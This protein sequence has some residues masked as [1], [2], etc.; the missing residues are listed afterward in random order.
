M[1]LA[2][3]SDLHIGYDKFAE[4]AIKQAKEA[5][6]LASTMADAILLP[7]DIFDKRYPR[8]EVMAQAINLFRDM[9]KRS[10]SAK[11]V[12]FEG[13]GKAYTGIPVV[14]ISGTHERTVEGKDNPLNLL[15]LAGFLVDTSEATTIIEKDDER[16]A[17]FG[18]GG[19][20]DERVRERLKELDPKPLP[21]AFNIFMFHQSI[22]ELLPFGNNIMRYDDLPKG[23]DLY[24]CGH[25]HNKVESVVHGKKF[26]ISGSTVL[27]QL[28]DGEQERKGFILFDTATYSYEF[29]YIN[30]REFIS[31]KVHFEEAEPKDVADG[32]ES[33]IESVLAKSSGRPIIRLNL[34]GTI[35][36]G[37][38]SLDM[39][40]RAIADRYA[41]RAILS[42]DASGLV[43]PELES[44]I[45]GIRDN[46]IGDVPIKE[47][48][49]G[50]FA[51]KLNELEFDES[52]DAS[53]LFEILSSPENKDKVVKEAGEF[54]DKG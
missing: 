38:T 12:S 44:S 47:L 23:F 50:L 31:K 45:A 37:F 10:W 41:G 42:I 3:V 49:M 28:K 40:I 1:K 29:K 7:G 39:P 53:E 52:I 30:S 35:K 32:C 22:Y 54:L 36:K 8:P 33:E 27:T 15:A 46:K 9:S 24:V 4:D 5:L 43:S 18:L 11:V 51:L 34:E 19:L 17:V 13:K 26:L 48:G 16:V 21:G 6:E 20:S 25:I 14:A 2:I